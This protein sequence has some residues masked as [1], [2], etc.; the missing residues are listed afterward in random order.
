M[1]DSEDNES[2]QSD[3]S[4]V[5]SDDELSTDKK[6]IKLVVD[7]VNV[8]DDVEAEAE[9]EAEDEDD[10]FDINTAPEDIIPPDNLN[11]PNK[12]L[13]TTPNFEKTFEGLEDNISVSSGEDEYEE[14]EE[15]EDYGK[16]FAQDID[17]NYIL[18]NHPE[19]ITHN[20]DEVSALT[21]I[22]R[23][24]KK[25]IID[26]LHKT[27]PFMTKF[28]K[29]KIIGL[30]ATQLSEGAQ[31]F[32][33]IPNN[34]ISSYVI[35]TMELEQKKIPFIIKRPIPN[36]GSEYWKIQDLEIII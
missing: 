7:E 29:A 25:E 5:F 35:A 23:N 32:I 22:K 13:L 10:Q 15:D 31:P 30:R 33:K 21:T 27:I 11:V 1:S 19:S 2:I 16:K 20:F 3:I 9:A 6:D 28:E 8:A 34:I 18:T 36:G 14:D 17:K 24:D 4:E 12:S 26:D